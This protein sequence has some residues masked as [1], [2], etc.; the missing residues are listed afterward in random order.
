[1]G[2]TLI[3][4]DVRERWM[5]PDRLWEPQRRAQYLLRNDIIKPLSTD[6]M[7]WPS[8]FDTG[9]GRHL[10]PAQRL[11]LG[12]GGVQAPSWIGPNPG[13]WSDHDRMVA[14][15]RHHVPEHSWSVRPLQVIAVTWL[16]DAGFTDAGEFGPYA[17]PTTPKGLR[18][19][20]I[21]LGYDVSDGSLLSGLSN[22]AYT[23]VER[24]ILRQE[25]GR[26]LNRYHLFEESDRASRFREITN[27]R[28]PEHAP[29]F[30]YGLYSVAKLGAIRPQGT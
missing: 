7:V 21:R 11:H 15:L 12:L 3:G 22:C 9:Q 2:E 25:W 16:S 14:T 5:L 24:D 26:R 1:M 18:P 10:D 6:V 13:L 27:R 4:F 19:E 28:V 20:W 30:V 29:F 8:I 23:D 17:E